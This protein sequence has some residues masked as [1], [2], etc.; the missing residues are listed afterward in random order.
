MTLITFPDAMKEADM[1]KTA[2][3]KKE[4]KEL[5][6]KCWMT[7]DGMWFYHCLQEC[8]IEKT[9]KV[10]LAAV[11]SLAAVEIKRLKKAAGI[12]TLET[13]GE[14]LEFFQFT[15]ATLTGE[16]MKYTFESK[17]MNRIH[18]TWHRCFAYEGIKALGAI[19]RYECGIMYRVEGWFDTLGIKYEVEP[20]VVHCM[21][22]TE[23][24]C[25]RD[26]TFF[27]ER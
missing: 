27:F 15:M 5:L 21:M 6:T 13:F 3:E 26:Y 24:R 16:F 17:G 4:L 14:F 22:H 19:D 12:E 1:D 8:G 20:K 9:N 10:N 23:G 7:H 25:Y 11:K 18:C 2:L